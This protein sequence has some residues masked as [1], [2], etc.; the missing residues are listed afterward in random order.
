MNNILRGLILLSVCVSGAAAAGPAT[1]Q[2]VRAWSVAATRPATTQSVRAW[3]VAATWPA[4]TQSVG[5]WSVAATW[6]ATTQSVGA[7]DAAAAG[8]ATTQAAQPTGAWAWFELPVMSKPRVLIVGAATVDAETLVH[9]LPPLR[10]RQVKGAP[11]SPELRRSS[12]IAEHGHE[13]W[14]PQGITQRRNLAR[15]RWYEVNG[16]ALWEVLLGPCWAPALHLDPK[17]QARHLGSGTELSPADRPLWHPWVG[18]RTASSSETLVL[19]GGSPV[20]AYLITQPP[21]RLQWRRQLDWGNL[22]LRA[23]GNPFVIAETGKYPAGVGSV[24][25]HDRIAY[26]A[27]DQGQLASI[28][29]GKRSWGNLQEAPKAASEIVLLANSDG[30][31][32]CHRSAPD[33]DWIAQRSRDG[34]TWQSAALP[35][36][37]P[38]L[39]PWFVGQHYFCAQSAP[40]PSAPARLTVWHRPEP[41]DDW[42]PLPALDLA[43]GE[44]PVDCLEHNN[45]LLLLIG[46][47]TPGKGLRFSVKTLSK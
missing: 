23:G 12:L 34:A 14:L 10:P 28:K 25:I 38:A 41:A 3:S 43:Q 22:P 11:G 46:T 5:A 36:M 37:K 2:A 8:P 30:V 33:A 26:V 17:E 32:L 16:G 47:E 20:H 6:P 29:L 18:S 45:R 31:W 15:I 42:T 39:K 27:S 24:A 40:S 35:K 19:I 44:I 4:T 21:S 9:E 1:T 7:S 13:Q